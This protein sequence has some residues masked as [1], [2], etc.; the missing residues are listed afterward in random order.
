M[1]M[2]I[3][4]TKLFIPPPRPKVVRRLHLIERLNEGLRRKLTLISAPAGFGKSTLVSEWIASCALPVAWLSLDIGDRDPTRFLN[5]LI[6]ALQTLALPQEHVGS[7]LTKTSNERNDANAQGKLAAHIGSRALGMLQSPQLQPSSLESTLT[8]LLNDIATI[9]H[10]FVLVLDDYHVIDAKSVDD[11]L[12]FLLEHLPPQM[13]L[14]IV[15][16]EDPDLPLARLRAQEQLTELRAAHLRFSAFEVGEFLNQVMGLNLSAEN[17]T[18]LE[19]RTEGWIAGLQLAAISMQGHRDVTG[20]IKSFTG[21]HHFVMDYLVEEVLRQQSESVQSFLL[22]TA[23][24]ERMCGPLCDAILLGSTPSPAGQV[25]LEALEHSNLFIIALDNERR[26][27]RYHH[28]FG[29]LLRQR[30]GQSLSSKEICELHLRASEWYEHNNLAFEAFQHATVANDI[31]RAE[32]LI[33]SKEM[34]LHFHSVA[35]PILDWL[36]SLPQTVFE[37]KPQLWVR[38]ATLALMAGQTSGVEEKLKAAE[39]ALQKI[40]LDEKSRDLIGQIA[41]AR[42]TLALTYYDPDTMIAQ[43]QRALEYLQP[44][45]LNFLFTAN[46]ALT[47]ALGYKGDRV[48]A[49][50][51]C[52]ES[53]AISQKSGEIFSKLLATYGWGML[54]VLDNQLYQ[55]AETYQYVLELSGKHPLPHTAEMHL[56]LAQI[57]YE[58]ND[59][60]AAERHG[61]QSL[62]LAR[63]YDPIID[64]FIFSEVFL[65]RV[66]LACGDVNGAATMLAQIEQTA[67]QKNFVLRLPE[68]AT[69]QV[70]VLLR[71]NRLDAAFALAQQYE[72]PMSQARVCSAQGNPSAALALLEPLRQR[73]ET[74]GWQDE[75]LKVLCFEALAYHTHNDNDKAMQTLSAALILAEPGGFIRLFVDEGEPMRLLLS[76][77]RTWVTEQGH[78]DHKTLGYVDKL[79]VAFSPQVTASAASPEVNLFPSPLID[80][81]S[82]RELEVLR[83]IAQGLSNQA[84]GERL[85]L[86]LSTVKGHNRIIFDKLAVKSRTE[87]IVRARELG[88]M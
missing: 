4:A 14:V 13:H 15:T 41:C 25:T 18:A 50:R 57:Y 30:L 37:A 68:I 2:P 27:Y 59:L 53:L 61:Q 55:A 8:M 72:L 22:R 20:F 12:G 45:N 23:V 28:L 11:A 47:T 67:R 49:A 86:A 60:D 48:A 29:D 79:L 36:A 31:D 1:A 32:R 17:I 84:I 66:K 69:V 56:G 3:L 75:R 9:P 38:S 82:P 16:R 73:A 5:Y 51:A 35:M 44:D 87:A 85:F 7:A 42:A 39:N 43:A 74:M 40:E 83:L 78:M 33:N 63:L 6:A 46:W 52:Q 26:W 34:Q 71:Q 81:L 19:T 88:L 62:Q 77:Y 54:Q 24:L 70:L 80:P 58:W 10:H 65:A 76:D 64:R 21:S